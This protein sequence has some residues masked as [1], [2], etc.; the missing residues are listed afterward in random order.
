[1]SW[2]APSRTGGAA[3]T[4]YDVYRGTASSGEKLV[5]SGVTGTSYIDSNITKGVTYY[6]YVAAVNSA[7]CGAKCTE[8]NAQIAL[9]S[10]TLHPSSPTV[11]IVIVTAVAATVVITTLLAFLN[12]RGN[13]SFKAPK[14][15]ILK[16][17]LKH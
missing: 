14:L 16:R 1:L 2:T 7:G 10:P 6:Y 3:V 11:T 17:L 15:G 8:V 9:P 13:L 4:S 12:R 5:A